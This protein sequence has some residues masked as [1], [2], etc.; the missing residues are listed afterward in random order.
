MDWRLILR[1]E[2]DLLGLVNPELAA[3][4]AQPE[5][6]AESLGLNLFLKVTKGKAD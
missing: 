6:I 4:K 3:Q 5:V 2:P 1:D